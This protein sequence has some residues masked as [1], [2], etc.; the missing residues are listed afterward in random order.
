MLVS[1]RFVIAVTFTPPDLTD[2]ADDV[3]LALVVLIGRAPTAVHSMPARLKLRTASATSRSLISSGA[4]YLHMA[5]SLCSTAMGSPQR[6]PVMVLRTSQPTMS[7]FTCSPS[8][9]LDNTIL[10]MG[11]CQSVSPYK[12]SH[13]SAIIPCHGNT[14]PRR[15]PVGH[16]RSSLR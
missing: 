7:G 11:L 12:A 14:V 6:M 1:C 13:S 10:F 2:G 9:C 3:G 4:Q 5:T 8:T 16:T 15:K